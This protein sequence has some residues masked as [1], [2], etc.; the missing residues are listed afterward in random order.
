[1]S[2]NLRSNIAWLSLALA[3]S[4]CV[5]LG[6]VGAKDGPAIVY[7]VMEDAGRAAPAASPSPRTLLMADTA[8]GA[9]YDTDGMAFSNK[10]GTRGYYQ[11]ARWSER[12]GKRFTDLL[13]LRLE[14]EKIFASVAQSGSNVSG[15]WLLI[16]E[17]L[18]FHHDAAQQPG[19]VK[20]ELRTEVVDLKTR[21]LVARKTFTQSVA[22]PSY[23]AAGAHKAFNEAAT[24]TLN[25][26]ADWLKELSAN[27]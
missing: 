10:S 2:M 23:N 7:Y 12:A 9:F 18:D 3:L 1:M 26:L 6:M 14:H 17:I 13:L 25:D 19:T 5:N 4:G 27:S 20:M 21:T 15:D 22:V 16:T 8:A 24:R 11:F